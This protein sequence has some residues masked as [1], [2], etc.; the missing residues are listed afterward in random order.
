MAIRIHN[1]YFRPVS[2]NNRK[3][4]PTCHIKL[5][6]T[7]SIWSWGEYISA[8]WRT[9]TYFCRSCY[10]QQVYSALVSHSNPCKCT[11]VLNMYRGEARP[12]WLDKQIG[13]TK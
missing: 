2:L 1:E 10:K 12:E 7:E 11:I 5:A 8:T 4:C 6:S 3:S 9:V 13:G